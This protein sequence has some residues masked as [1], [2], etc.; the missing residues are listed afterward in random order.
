[1]GWLD[2][3]TNNIIL[4]AV[5]TDYGRQRLASSRGDFKIANFALGDDEIDYRII[6]KYGRTVGKEKIEKN[7][8]I[9]EALTNPNIALK[10][11]LVSLADTGTSVQTSNLPYLTSNPS[12]VSLTSTTSFK[13]VTITQ[14][15]PITAGSANTLST[16]NLQSAYYIK[17]SDRFFSIVAGQNAT[18]TNGG[19]ALRPSNLSD[20]NR[21]VEYKLN[22]AQGVSPTANSFGFRVQARTS[23]IDSTTLSIYGSLLGTGERVITSNITIRGERF[24][25]TINIPITYTAK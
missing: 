10:Y 2:H 6:K 17:I 7:T 13:D 14:E 22:I 23:S 16:S 9:F 19:G 3:S 1:M 4:D 18:L 12:T 21:I 5:L 15:L 8:P 20:P 11:Q 25:T 24:G